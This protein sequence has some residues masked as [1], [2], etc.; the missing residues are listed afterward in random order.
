MDESG[1]VPTEAAREPGVLDTESSPSHWQWPLGGSGAQV[2][3]WN[4]I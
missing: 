3:L 4:S 1:A 2:A